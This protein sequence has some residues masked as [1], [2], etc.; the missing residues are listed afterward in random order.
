VRFAERHDTVLRMERGL[1]NLS[2][3]GCRWL[4]CC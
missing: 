1:E 4:Q 2:F 3:K